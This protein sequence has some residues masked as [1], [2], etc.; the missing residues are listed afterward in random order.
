MKLN[1]RMVLSAILVL[2]ISL[3]MSSCV[4]NETLFSDV[5]FTYKYEINNDI[6]VLGGLTEE[7]MQQE[8]L[9]FP[10]V[11]KGRK[12]SGIGIEKMGLDSKRRVH[13]FESNKLK[14]VYLPNGYS[15]GVGPNIEL[16]D[17]LPNVECIYYVDAPGSL[18]SKQCVKVIS[19]RYILSKKAEYR[20]HF[21]EYYPNYYSAN[22][23]YYM[24]D[25]TD[26][27]YFVDHVSGTKVNVKP[28][29]PYREGY[30]FRAWYKDKELTTLWD[31][32]ND[33]IP[34]IKL[35][36]E[37]KEIIET[38]KIYAGWDLKN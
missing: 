2:F 29:T 20:E 35:D 26:D 24:N 30:Q 11:I 38:T 37:G 8:T 31:F 23:A 1:I 9:V 36:E 21:S 3:T 12:V 14:N 25:G 13:Y 4:S 33:I 10:S 6:L 22:V 18:V 5:Y 27:I 7:G 34:E 32:E 15:I 19:N 17:K 16:Y 28:S